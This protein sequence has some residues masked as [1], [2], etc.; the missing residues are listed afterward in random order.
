VTSRA[1]SYPDVLGKSVIGEI[2]RNQ[3]KFM[4]WKKR[5]MKFLLASLAKTKK[6]DDDD[7]DGD[8]DFA[9]ENDLFIVSSFEFLF[10]F[11][12]R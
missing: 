1:D 10:E 9:P 7:G 8:L 12:P 5:T 4:A 3:H 2:P 6:D 11:S